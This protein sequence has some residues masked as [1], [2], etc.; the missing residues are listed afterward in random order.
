[1]TLGKLRQCTPTLGRSLRET[2]GFR[3]A[4]VLEGAFRTFGSLS[5]CF[6][7][8]QQ[9]LI[10]TYSENT[11]F[12]FLETNDESELFDRQILIFAL[13]SCVPSTAMSV[14]HE[15]IKCRTPPSSLR[16]VILHAFPCPLI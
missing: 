2:F 3:I 11:L 5:I 12:Q 8:M 16:L 13:T 10:R 14:V 7:R 6:C 9:R 15:A 4:G 1:M